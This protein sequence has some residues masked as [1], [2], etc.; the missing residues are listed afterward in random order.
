MSEQFIGNYRV[1]NMVGQGGM[2]KVYLAVHK[3]VPNLRV[4]LKI[5]S[6]PRLADRFK[7][8]ADKLAL[9]D[10]HPNICQIKHFFHHGEDLVIAME[11]ID[12]ATLDERLKSDKRVPIA[13]AVRIVSDM[14]AILSYAHEREISHR[15]IKPSNVMIDK[16]GQVKI[17]DFG[18]AK[19]KSDPN[20]TMT[21]ASL[22]TPAYMA[23]EQF[24]PTDSTDYALADIY[25]CGITLYQMVTGELPFKGD[26]EFV[27]R[28][29]KLMGTVTPP[30]SLNP[31][32]SKELEGIILKAIDKDPSQR[33]A[34]AEEMRKALQA[35]HRDDSLKADKPT[36]SVQ[37]TPLPKK[38]AG[39]KKKPPIAMLLLIP[40]VIVVIAVGAWFLFLRGGEAGPPAAPELMGP[41]DG[42]RFTDADSVPI[43]WSATAGT[44]GRYM[45]EYA[46]DSLFDMPK[47][48]S[49]N[50][51]TFT[52]P[53]G[54]DP[55]VYYWQVTPTNA[56]GTE[57]TPSARRTFTIK[58]TGP[59]QG[60][61]VVDVDP[62]GDIYVGGQLLA[63]DQSSAS[64]TLDTGL[65]DVRVDN[66]ESKEKT[67]RD[68][69]RVTAGGE[70]SRDFRFTFAENK[71]TP[72]KPAIKPREVRVGSRPRGAK[73]Y[74]DDELQPVQTNNTVWLKPGR[75]VVKVSMELNGVEQTRTKTLEISADSVYKVLFEFEQ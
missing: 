57:G 62:S 25:A 44:G 23:P 70:V 26:N 3:D 59:P 33:Y 16:S 65:Y 50:D 54:Q 68:T 58:S 7:Q 28:D 46:N 61:V 35:V 27:L 19:G 11:Y 71:P 30:R 52:F 69:V 51:S 72:P 15:D 67:L 53:P 56:D 24:I 18:I 2:G 29:A 64:T 66:A 10:G 39:S 41:P 55:G 42:A 12:G 60:T 5:L 13:E 8:E 32:V 73:I 21:G 38:P 37:Q 45:I 63:R 75:H 43:V 47:K 20:L 4:I 22:G 40:S 34:S 48:F 1:V 49:W 74:V 36:Q 9:L 17:I 6:D 14:L 31:G